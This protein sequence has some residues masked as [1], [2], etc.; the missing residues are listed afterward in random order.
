M[1]AVLKIESASKSFD[2]PEGG[3][4]H[5][6]RDVSLT[7]AHNEFVTLL[8]PSGCGKTTMLRAVSGFE[9]LDA[10]EIYI[11]G[12]GMGSRPAHKRPVNTVFQRYALFPHLSVA[13]N[14]SYSL[15]VAGVDKTDIRKRV[16]DMLDMVGL[17]ALGERR[18]GQLSG[19]QQQRVALARS[20]VARPKVLLL[21][22]PLSALDKNLR[23]KMQEELKGLQDELGITFIFVTHDQEEA[24]VMSDRIAVLEGGRIQQL[25]APEALYR[26]PKNEFVARFIGESNLL[27]GTIVSTGGETCDVRLSDGTVLK[28]C[29]RGG[30]DTGAAVKVLIRPE[31]V[32]ASLSEGASGQA[33]SGTISQSYFIGTDYQIV[34]LRDGLPPFRATV[35]AQTDASRFAPGETIDLFVPHEGVHLI[36]A[37]GTAG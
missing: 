24:L 4:I 27:P 22:E 9:D 14:V 28:G 16:G 20:L 33:I 19:G 10:G 36:A 32:V 35:R 21:D 34:V 25:D 29:R 31:S 7:I 15:E 2:A 18:I 37:E 5:A 3:R 8:G 13:R 30:L 11:E 1:S 26:Y 23:H 6:L 17:S 12:E